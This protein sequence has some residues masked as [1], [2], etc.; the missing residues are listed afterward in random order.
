M[1]IE[2]LY[3]ELDLIF[4]LNKHCTIFIQKNLYFVGF[5][6]IESFKRDDNNYENNE[7]SLFVVV[8]ISNSWVLRNKKYN[9]RKCL[10]VS[11]QVLEILF[12]IFDNYIWSQQ[13]IEA[14][15]ENQ[16]NILTHKYSGVQT[17]VLRIQET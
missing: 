16:R 11:K 10:I 15:H 1:K 2:N 9:Y 7:F 12:R 8:P 5:N 17:N 13:S 14:V 3:T 4:R 6:G